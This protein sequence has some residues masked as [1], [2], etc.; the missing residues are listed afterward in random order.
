MAGGLRSRLRRSAGHAYRR[1]MA[2]PGRRALDRAVAAGL[3]ARLEAPLRFLFDGVPP[4][5]AA[6]ASARI[7]RRRQAIAEDRRRFGFVPVPTPV[8]EARWLVEASAAAGGPAVSPSWLARVASVPAR[9]GIFLHLCAD[10][11]PGGPVLELGG[12]VGIGSA[13][14]A[15]ARGCRGLVTLEGSPVVAPI[16]RATLEALAPGAIVVEGAFHETLGGVLAGRD[17]G[18][19]FDL[20]YLDGHHDEAATL[21]YVR[22]V[23]A[24]LR[25]GGLI[26]LDD[27][28]LYAEMWR[29]WRRLSATPGFSAA[30]NVGRFGLLVGADAASTALQLDFSRYTGWWRVGGARRETRLP[31]DTA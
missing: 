14:L 15:T 10:G 12:C 27:I 26:V 16:A 7:E 18:E 24:A 20:V 31:A 17:G 6:E 28:Y 9:W 8:G 22:R 3:P 1:V 13:Y 11:A 21:D 5:R 2:V 23:R 29:A 30:V 25:P 19:R 4:A